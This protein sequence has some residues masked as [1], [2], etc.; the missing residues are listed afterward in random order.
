MGLFQQFPNELLHRVD[1]AVRDHL[2]AAK[3]ESPDGQSIS[4]SGANRRACTEVLFNPS[5][6][7]GKEGLPS[8]VDP[9]IQLLKQCD[10][11]KWQ[12]LL[13]P[14]V[15]IGG[16]T[17]YPGFPERFMSELSTKLSLL[18]NDSKPQ[19]VNQKREDRKYAAWKGAAKLGP[20]LWGVQQNYYDDD[21]KS[22]VKIQ[23]VSQSYTNIYYLGTWITKEE[24]DEAGNVRIYSVYYLFNL[25]I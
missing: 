7:N 21:N 11:S 4:I 2:L 13:S 9:I 10:E 17:L 22:V 24:Y 8:I 25:F 15:L 14:I 18:G 19:L 5:L 12:A 1:N 6:L 3:F 23:K 20:A 16:N